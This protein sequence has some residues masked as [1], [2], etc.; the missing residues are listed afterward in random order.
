MEIKQA[1]LGMLDDITALEQLV[2]REDSATPES[3]R[4][5]IE[6]FPESFCAVYSNNKL[7]GMAMS[8]LLPKNHKVGEYEDLFFS[9]ERV[10]NPK[11]KILYLYCSTT[12][13]DFRF[14]GIWKKMLDFRLNY[15]RNHSEI[16]KVWVAA[17][18][19]ENE[20]GS[21]TAEPLKRFGFLFVKDILFK[22]Q[23]TQSLLDFI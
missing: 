8:A 18:N 11:G 4:K 9:W 6:I 14:Q 13:P 10:H 2:W 17:R 22:G 15:A 5:R 12:H 1:N 16:E 21:N 20:I 23:Y 3:L 19:K 7:V